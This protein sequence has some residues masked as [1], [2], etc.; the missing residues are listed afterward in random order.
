MDQ[1]AH[2]MQPTPQPQGIMGQIGQGLERF[3]AIAQGGTDPLV[4]QQD[5]QRKQQYLL[6]N[7]QDRVN[8][9]REKAQKVQMDIADGLIASDDPIA[10][11]TGWGY[12]AKML[13]EQGFEIPQPVLDSLSASK[14]SKADIDRGASLAAAGAT[15]PEFRL[16]LPNQSSPE[17]IALYRKMG[18]SAEYTKKF[19]GQ[20]PEQAELAKESMGIRLRSLR[21]AEIREQSNHEYRMAQ[22]KSNEE[23]L[24][25]TRRHNLAMEGLGTERLGK[26]VSTKEEKRKETFG[27]MRDALDQIDEVSA[28]LDKKHYLPKTSAGVLA[29]DPSAV[30]AEA[31]QRM[32]NNDRD[33]RR[34]QQLQATII[35]FDRSVMND[36]GARA[37]AAFKNQFNFFDHPPTKESI[38]AV[39]KQM[40]R[41]LDK[42]EKNPSGM[43]KLTIKTREGKFIEGYWKPGE[44]L[45]EGQIVPSQEDQ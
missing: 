29:L 41:L 19:T 42:A 24:A 15:D 12:K 6:M 18:S 26:A 1:L 14:A 32:F 45:P 8:R 11:K 9:Q 4:V 3:G 33:W 36:I 20:T 35:G 38:D 37:F 34:W 28:N 43:E 25:E 21:L 13:K 5:Q 10:K 30:R 7:V 22:A 17:H 2:I 23:R 39:V 31:N 16:A 27:V 40:R 44:P